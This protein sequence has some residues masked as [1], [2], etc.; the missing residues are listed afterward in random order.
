M[1]YQQCYTKQIKLKYLAR[2]LVQVF[3]NTKCILGS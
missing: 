1:Y 2:A 3:L